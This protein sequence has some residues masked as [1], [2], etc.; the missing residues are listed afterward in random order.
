MTIIKK[1]KKVRVAA[2]VIESSLLSIAIGN[3][4]VEIVRLRLLATEL[5]FSPNVRMSINVF[6]INRRGTS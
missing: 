1:K 2:V 4:T 5:V 6:Y 3:V